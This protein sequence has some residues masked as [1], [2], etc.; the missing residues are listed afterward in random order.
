MM[1]TYLDC[2]ED[3]Q[4]SPHFFLPDGSSSH[5]PGITMRQVGQPGAGFLVVDE[6][7]PEVY[8]QL[9]RRAVRQ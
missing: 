7:D 1:R 9:V 3:V 5:N 2:R 8:A 6:D 4:G